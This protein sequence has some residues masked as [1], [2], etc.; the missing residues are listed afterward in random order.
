MKITF[1]LVQC[2]IVLGLVLFYRS[3]IANSNRDIMFVLFLAMFINTHFYLILETLK[4][5]KTTTEPKE[6]ICYLL[7]RSITIPFLILYCINQFRYYQIK[8]K[9]LVLQAT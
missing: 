3:R 6:Y 1:Y 2:W 7:Y 5:I 9:V 8:G 4:L